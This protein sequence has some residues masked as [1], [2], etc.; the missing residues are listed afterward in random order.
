M[1]QL[2]YGRAGTGKTRRLMD[3]LCAQARQGK[4]VMLLVPE[5]VSFESERAVYRLLGAQAAQNVEVLSFTRLA[6]L[7]FRRFGGGAGRR[8]DEPTRLLLMSAALDEVS[9]QLKLYADSARDSSFL[10]MLTQTVAQFKFAGLTPQKLDDLTGLL[11]GD[12]TSDLPDKLRELSLIYG[13]FQALVE[14]QYSDPLD[15]LARAE[16]LAAENGFFLGWNL[17][18]DGF[19]SFTGAELALLQVAAEDCDNVTA[20]FSGLPEQADDETSMFYSSLKSGAALAAAS[21]QAGVDVAEP[22]VLRT[23]L[24]FEAPGLRGAEELLAGGNPPADECGGLVLARFGQP[25]DEVECAAAEIAQLVRGQGLRYRDITVICRDVERYRAALETVFSRYGI[26]LFLD[27]VTDL[28]SHPL[29]IALLAALE[30]VRG[31]FDTGELLNLAKTPVFGLT[32]DESARL[33][34]Y[35]FVWSVE[36]QDWQRDFVVSPKGLRRG[37]GGEG[38]QQELDDLNALRRR[39]VEPLQPLLGL[40]KGCTGREFARACYDFLQ[41]AGC[42]DHLRDFCGSL[43]EQERKP[44]QELAEAVWNSLM[45]LL[46]VFAEALGTVRCPLARFLDLLQMSVA[47]VEVGQIPSTLDQVSAGSADRVRPQS[48]KAVF[49]LGANEGVFP[50]VPGRGGI[51]SDKERRVLEGSGLQLGAPLFQ[52]ILEERFFFYR[53]AACASQRLYVLC[54]RA[55]ATGADLEP[56]PQFQQLCEAFPQALRQEARPTGARIVNLATAEEELARHFVPG[57]PDAG[58]IAE[59]LRRHGRGVQVERLAAA[60]DPQPAGN[61]SSQDA[62]G[63]FGGELVLSASQIEDFY[64]CPFRYFCRYGLRVE[65]LQRAEFSPLVSGTA[66]HAVLEQMVRLHGG[67]ALG[68]MDPAAL[69][70]E[71]VEL[72]NQYLEGLV[73]DPQVLGARKL[74]L[75]NRMVSIL[76]RV[77]QRLGGEFAQSVFQ[78]AGVEVRVGDGGPVEALRVQT[79]SGSV[80]V[81]GSI[82]RVDLMELDGQK[83]ARVVDYKSGGKRFDLPDVYYGLNMQMLVYLYALCGGGKGQYAGCLPAGI[84]YFPAKAEA[85]NLPRETPQQ[86]ADAKQGASMHM[87]GLLLRD[88]KVLEAMEQNLAEEYI[89]AALKKDNAFSTRSLTASQEEFEKIRRHVMRLIGEMGDG[90]CGGRVAPDPADGGGPRSCENCDYAGLC[91]NDRAGD[92]PA[93]PEVKVDEFYALLDREEGEKK[94]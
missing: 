85:L 54:A 48:P 38:D 58:S 47:M 7:V 91:H 64:R 84:L 31:G 36:G 21:A 55:E 6:N 41:N 34:N 5:Q 69:H 87:N 14:R 43:P 10:Q 94:A 42:P 40:V 63:L 79:Q 90:L 16:E 92:R 8:L 82:D 25:Y 46:D 53:S 12:E 59:F 52:A 66:I 57:D 3:S 30:A 19:M 50:A 24:R 65:P 32:V 86:E 2:V 77:L 72:M 89:P 9:G 27:R 39:V 71:V 49:L 73:A 56:S 4:K 81:C 83:Y 70:A 75:F 76:V 80:S 37:A 15:D 67:K 17:Y 62:A 18:L 93:R 29:V 28:R 33:E 23:P 11:P 60:E 26:P 44:A 78:P 22:L 1:L 74:Y 35:C 61:I 45:G 20:A 68:E 51:F 88:R 13:A